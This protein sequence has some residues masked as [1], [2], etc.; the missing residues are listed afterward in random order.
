MSELEAAVD[1]VQLGKLDSIV[2]RFHSVKMRILKQLHSFR[3]IRPQRLNDPAGEVGYT[4][5]FFPATVEL[6]IQIVQALAAEGIGASILGT[7]RHPNWHIYADMFPLTLKT[8]T[9]ANDHPFA[10]SANGQKG[11]EVDYSR[12]LCPVA[13]DLFERMVSIWLNQ[14]YT[15]SDCEHIASGLNKVFSAYCSQHTHAPAWV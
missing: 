9:M 12:G 11:K 2:Q 14:W 4:L 13:D 15:P 6:G 3:E 5:R 10:L 7:N 8:G 1:V